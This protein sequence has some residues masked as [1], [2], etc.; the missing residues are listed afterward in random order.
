LLAKAGVITLPVVAGVWM[1]LDGEVAA[2]AI[3]VWHVT[4]GR[5]VAPE[6]S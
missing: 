2:R 1:T 4:N 3:K 5:V 6:Q